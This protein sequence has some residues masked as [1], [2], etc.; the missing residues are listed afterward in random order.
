[1]SEKQRVELKSLILSYSSL[2]S[3]VPACTKVMEHDIDVEDAAP[4]R[5]RFYRVPPAKQKILETE[6]Q[7]LIDNG[8]AKSS[9]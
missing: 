2:F 9:S 1:M 8:L 7:Y 6:V 4:I 3:D 5:Q